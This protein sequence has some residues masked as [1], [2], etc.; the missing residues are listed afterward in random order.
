M[1]GK[2]STRAP[3]LLALMLVATIVSCQSRKEQP[4]D[5]STSEEAGP[6]LPPER[7]YPAKY[8]YLDLAGRQDFRNRYSAA[9]GVHTS[10]PTLAGVHGQCSGVLLSPRLVLTAGHCVCVRRP[11]IAPGYEGRFIIDGTSCSQNPIVTT[12]LWVALRRD[13]FLPSGTSRE[14]YSGVEVR[15]HPEFQVFI[16]KAGHVEFSRADLALILLESPIHGGNSPLRIADE[17]IRSGETFVLVGGRG[18]EFQGGT[19]GSDRRFMRY[20]AL[21]SVGPG[22]DRILFEQPKRDLFNGDS[23]GPCIH[24]SP[25][26]LSL[27]GISARSLGEEPTFTSI[28]PYLDWLHS[29]IRSASAGQ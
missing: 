1:N 28:H 7:P 12:H 6:P 24:E 11:V 18:D 15:P 2:S 29:A 8:Y 21:G 20:K 10:E 13:D 9:V 16:D 22:S 17:E 26:G 3:T 14:E 27:V 19:A 25:E 4:P 5:S 23:G